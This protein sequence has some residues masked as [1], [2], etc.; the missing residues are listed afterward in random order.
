MSEEVKSEVYAIIVHLTSGRSLEGYA[1]QGG[2]IGGEWLIISR[3]PDMMSPAYINRDM[4]IYFE[5]AEIK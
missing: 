3:E 4:V 2:D 5:L 1:P